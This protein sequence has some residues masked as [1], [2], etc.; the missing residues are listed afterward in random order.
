MNVIA[1]LVAALALTA[2]QPEEAPPPF[3]GTEAV[4]TN[5][6]QLVDYFAQPGRG[7]T[8]V[9]FWEPAHFFPWAEP[10]FADFR[11]LPAE[12]VALKDDS[13]AT[14][15]GIPFWPVRLIK[16]VA[17]GIVM[18]RHPWHDRDLLWLKG[19]PDFTLYDRLLR[20]WGPLWGIQAAT[21]ATTTDD[22][23]G[24]LDPPRL[25]L[26]VWLA[27]IADWPA[28]ERYLSAEQEAWELDEARR[29]AGDPTEGGAGRMLLRS[30]APCTI[31]NEAQPFAVFDVWTET[32]GWFA[33]AWES[34]SDHLY[35]VE[36]AAELGWPTV[37]E[38]VATLP[39]DDGATTWTD[40]NA[41]AFPHRFYRVRR[42][43]NFD[44]D[45][46]GLNTL[47]E[48]LWG[49]DPL[50]PDT[51]G[52]GMPDGWEVRY[53]LDPTDSADA[54][55]D[56]DGDGVSNLDEYRGGTDPTDNTSLPPPPPT[57]D[58]V[59]DAL[60]QFNFAQLNLLRG[61]TG[62]GALVWGHHLNSADRINQARNALEA[63]LPSF[64]NLTVNTGGTLANTNT[65]VRWTLSAVLQAAGYGG[66]AWLSGD[67]SVEQV[68]QLTAVLSRLPRLPAAGG[69]SGGVGN[70]H[71][72]YRDDPWQ[73]DTWNVNFSYPSLWPTN[74][75]RRT[76]LHL[77]ARRGGDYDCTIDDYVKFNAQQIPAGSGYLTQ[78]YTF[79][80]TGAWDPAGNTMELW[81]CG[82]CAGGEDD[83]YL[84]PYQIVHVLEV[85]T[86]TGRFAARP[87]KIN[88]GFDPTV[89]DPWTSVGVGNDNEIVRLI[90][91]PASL[92]E[93]VTLV[94]GS[95]VTVTPTA[96]TGAS[97][98]LTI[99]GV[100][101]N[102]DTPLE[103]RLGD[104]R[105]A[106]LHVMVLP[107]RTVNVGIYR[108]TDSVTTN[109]VPDGAPSDDSVLTALNDAFR[110]ACISFENA[111]AGNP[112]QTITIRYDDGNTTIDG[113]TN[114]AN[115]GRIEFE[116][117]ATVVF[118][119]LW[120]GQRRL[121]F[122]KNSGITYAQDPTRF[123]RGN[124]YPTLV[125]TFD[126]FVFTV[127]CAQ[128]GDSMS[129]V[130]AHEMGHTLNLS[131]RRDWWGQ[132]HDIGPYGEPHVRGLM[133]PGLNQSLQ[134]QN[135][136]S[137]WM[138]REDWW[139]ANFTLRP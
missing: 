52:D 131:T 128:A 137:V 59:K 54:S 63:V 3:D 34:C 110:Q 104:I 64:L 53:G 48:F 55:A 19:E 109:T 127:N 38:T 129:L 8:R 11:Q 36:I 79:E 82:N 67:P 4:L 50:N 46:D 37:W 39:G 26:D 61:L 33:L 80:I 116:E 65:V 75:T 113:W 108:L 77:L 138:R 31:T 118:T 51:D 90:V 74:W 35:T 136:P 120:S 57:T 112:D 93:A 62:D 13:P 32:N 124:A 103:A 7:P 71:V 30:G 10:W 24:W 49:T 21:Y 122:V 41:A 88:D 102:A 117:E 42:L 76:Y 6:H 123:V 5:T 1:G 66:G 44:A 134:I 130:A 73:Y 101:A 132:R 121:F 94:P 69:G 12:L 40:T 99:G 96:P 68:T 107:W 83:V 23:R 126:G 58:P 139:E 114:R 91:E 60:D 20:E 105:L 111:N 16:D 29:R 27:D 45:G 47:Q 125:G 72:E 28:Y 2:A 87:G 95:A 115:N 106:T 81:D 18:V 133:Q 89:A 14:A 15:D 135:I 78:D 86:I 25:V 56:A 119:N 85:P 97:T 70:Q 17:T 9:L 92:A 43:D 100:T 84:A 22:E 98:E